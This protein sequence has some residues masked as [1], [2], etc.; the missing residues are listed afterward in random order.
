MGDSGNGGFGVFVD[1]V[2]KFAGSVFG[3]TDQ[4]TFG[5][6][7]S[8]TNEPTNAPTNAPTKSPTTVPTA[9]P[10]SEPTN[11]PTN[12]PT[13]SHTTVP[14]ATPT[15]EPTNAPTNAPTG[16]PC[17]DHTKCALG[18]KC[19]GAYKV[20]KKCR[21]KMKD[22]KLWG[23]HSVKR[24]G[25]ADGKSCRGEADAKWGSCVSE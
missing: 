14:T 6:C 12:A 15:N 9:T 25:C 20:A 22:C 5:L 11:A 23:H 18:E 7:E 19:K 1:D 3:W 16:G 8:S 21:S 17:E 24:W 2:S 13:K 4:K 10:T